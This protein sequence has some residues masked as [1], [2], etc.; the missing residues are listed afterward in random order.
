MQ[1]EREGVCVCTH[2]CVCER[3]TGQ[4]KRVNW[5]GPPV[6]HIVLIKAF[7]CRMTAG[8]WLWKC[9]GLAS[10][11]P[12]G[13]TIT[14][15]GFD[16]CHFTEGKAHLFNHP[17]NSQGHWLPGTTA[18]I[19][20]S[21]TDVLIN[22][23]ISKPKKQFHTLLKCFKYGVLQIDCSPAIKKKKHKLVV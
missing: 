11:T 17:R 20:N 7:E 14:A 10:Q 6:P 13:V 15:S 21:I 3:E 12:A 1:F 18:C 2:M 23:S 8:I 19:T 16:L 9:E 4:W 22:L 5:T